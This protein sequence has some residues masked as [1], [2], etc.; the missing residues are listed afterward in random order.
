VKIKF[1][2]Q[3][4]IPKNEKMNHFNKTNWN[5]DLIKAFGQ[6]GIEVSTVQMSE[7]GTILGKKWNKSAIDDGDC[8]WIASLVYDTGTSGWAARKDQVDPR[9]GEIRSRW[10]IENAKYFSTQK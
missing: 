9:D 5:A 7:D 4:V 2:L 10:P 8:D 1:I 6:T 3:L